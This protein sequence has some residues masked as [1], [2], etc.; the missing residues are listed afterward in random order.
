MLF[1]G[2]LVRDFGYFILAEIEVPR[3]IQ[4]LT[5]NSKRPGSYDLQFDACLPVNHA[6]RQIALI[7]SPATLVRVDSS[8]LATHGNRIGNP[9][10]D[11]VVDRCQQV[12]LLA[13]IHQLGGVE[14][15]L[16]QD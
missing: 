9:L 2:S 8:R 16:G 11:V 15:V 12:P 5:E 10:G 14:V 1:N 3:K 13:K 4:R 7:R 6:V